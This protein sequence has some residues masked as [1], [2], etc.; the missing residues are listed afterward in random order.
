MKKKKGWAVFMSFLHH[1]PRFIWANLFGFFA[2][3]GILFRLAFS[4]ELK[5]NYKAN[6]FAW[7]NIKDID[8]LCKFFKDVY[9]YKWD[10]YKGFFDHN[11][12]KL[13]F[14]TVFGDC[15]D[16]GYWACKK[17]KEIYK[18]RLDFCKMRGYADLTA[19]PPFYHYDCVYRFK[20]EQD[21]HLFNY[22]KIKT[23]LN[24]EEL[25][26]EMKNMYQI[27]YKFKDLVSWDCNYR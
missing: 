23:G 7:D 26:E 5:D 12:G 9:Q 24:I 22:G 6:K 13:E 20:D 16:M 10:G 4:K 15:D 27:S 3:I 14:L 19:T 17:I 2:W 25:D 21:Y 1:G 11:N 8:D 18:G